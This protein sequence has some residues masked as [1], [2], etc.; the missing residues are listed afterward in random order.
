V[1]RSIPHALQAR[2]Q[3]SVAQSESEHA[4]PRSIAYNA[5]LDGLRAL[6]VAAV[7]AQHFSY[8]IVGFYGV[9]IFFVLSGY[10]ITSLLLAEREQ[11]G[12]ID[13]RAFYR[14]RF[15]RLMPAL[16]LVSGAIVVWLVA[17]AVPVRTWF[18]GLFGT[19]TYS[20]D[21]LSV[22]HWQSSLSSSF[23]WS[24]SL[25]VEEQ[26]YLVWPALILLCFYAS[27]RSSRRLLAASCV[28]LVAL[29]WLLRWQM[30]VGNATPGRLNFSIESHVDALALGAL[31]ALLAS[32]RRP[33]RALRSV[34]TLAG[35]VAAVLLYM[36]MT[37]HGPLQRYNYDFDVDGYGP[38]ALA[39][40]VVVLGLVWAPRSPLARLLSL[41]PLVYL[42]RLSY[43]IYL[44]NMLVKHMYEKFTGAHTGDNRWAELV[45]FGV[46]VLVCELSFRFVETPLRK[47]WSHRPQPPVQSG[48][49]Q[50]K[51]LQ[52]VG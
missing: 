17:T 39:S 38:V 10:L 50:E 40:A 49:E 43:G 44:W 13:F 41:R 16:V 51:T 15:A 27:V 25:S 5:S 1:S 4:R 21:L 32:G 12:S 47:R 35:C 11:T 48:P 29:S 18:V 45:A 19:L 23:E 9:S 28:A 8:G 20:T 6:A 33:G 52:L 37:G 42:G 7:V 14:R 36:A 3:G 31:I 46:L 2:A 24:W 26:F 30:A 22:T 34:L